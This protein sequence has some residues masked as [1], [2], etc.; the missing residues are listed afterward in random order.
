MT[1]ER[2]VTEPA[3]E[4]PVLYDVDVAIAG[5][6]LCSTFAAIAAGRLGART[7]LLDRM[8]TVG[9]NLGSAGMI[10]GG[11][12]DEEGE[13]TLPGGRAGIVKEFL[14]RVEAL[15]ASGLRASE[16]DGTLSAFSTSGRNVYCE[17]AN[18]SSYVAIQM[19]E[20]AG[21]ELLLSAYASDPIIEDGCVRG[22]FVECKGGRRAVRAKVTVDGTGDADLAARAGAAIAPYLEI[23]GGEGVD[24]RYKREAVPAGMIRDGYMR[25]EY[26]TY[27]NDTMVLCL[28]GNVDA[29]KTKAFAADPGAPTPEEQA[30][31]E[32]HMPHIP[33]PFQKALAREWLDGGYTIWPDIGDD[34]KASIATHRQFDYGGGLRAFWVTARGPINPS[35]PIQLTRLEVRLRQLAFEAVRF[36]RRRIG[37]FEHAYLVGTQPFL[38]FRGG[39]RIEGEH[40]LT[41]EEMF[42]ATRFDD[43]L[44]L[45]LHEALNHGGEPG[46][47]D[48]PL[49]CTIPKGVD[50]LIVCGRGAAYERRGHDPSGMRARPSMMVFGQC[51][52]AAAAVA[53]LDGV[54]PRDVDIRK[55]QQ[56]L[57]D[58]GIV[59]GEAERLRELGL[60]PAKAGE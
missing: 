43:V 39:A 28:V 18:I 23:A 11:G 42:A 34:I 14:D 9:G 58:D 33:K 31:I 36:L 12:L 40:T 47:F 17:D 59:L 27:Y 15:R 54:S 5:A 53:A 38:G 8:P 1:T 52:G 55:V 48:V 26:P 32:E 37:G 10:L 44:Y 6:G 30:V 45:N 51:V 3:R 16:D 56:H 60:T 50:G 49:S 4:R 22:L 41:V 19:L 46:G 24:E 29:A 57:V 7:L 2:T 35:D 25:K 13:A 20:E 21:V